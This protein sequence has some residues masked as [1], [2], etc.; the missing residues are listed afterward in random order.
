PAAGV[1]IG[2][3]DCRLALTERFHLGAGEREASLERFIN[4]IIKARL[5]IVGDDAQLL[6]GFIGSLRCHAGRSQRLLSRSRISVSSS[7]SLDGAGGATFSG[8]F[9]R[10]IAL[11]HRNNTQA[12][13]RKL[14][15]RVRKLPHARTA[16]CF[17]AS[18]KA[19]AVTF[20]ESGM[21]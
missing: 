11:I 16:P 19:G 6:R 15:K 8:A 3:S 21:K 9:N 5:A 17:F 1:S 7:T 13:I 2:L 20:D 10:L 14:I 12:M 4:E 18:T